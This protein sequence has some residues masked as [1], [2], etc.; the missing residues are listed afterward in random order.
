MLFDR[1]LCQVF[2]CSVYRYPALSL[3]ADCVQMAD[4]FG[5]VFAVVKHLSEVCEQKRGV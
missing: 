5:Q 1:L 2:R 3:F 4:D